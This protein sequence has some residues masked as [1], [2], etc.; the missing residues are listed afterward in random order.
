MR[1]ERERLSGE[2]EI[3]LVELV[4]GVWRRKLWVAL[5]AVPIIGLSI[6]YVLLVPPVYEAKLYVQPPSQNEIAQLNNARGGDSGLATYSV[7]DVYDIYLK[8]LQSEALRNKFFRTEYLAH[9][10]DEQRS[11]SRD[12][13]YSHFNSLI[14]VSQAGKDMPSRYVVT[15]NLEDPRRAADWVTTYVEMASERAKR[16]VLKGSHSDLAIMADNLERQI[17]AAQ[18]GARKQREDQIAQL[19]EALAVAESIGLKRP[20]ILAGD[21]SSEI[22]AGMGGSLTYM[23]GSEALRAEID[24]LK[25]R[26]SDDPFISEL[27]SRQ[28]KLGIY[29]SISIDP[30]AIAVYQ[31]DGAVEQPDKPIKPKKSLIVLLASAAGL[32]LGVMVALARDVWIRRRVMA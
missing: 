29:R 8:A 14:K 16:E 18:A 26:V 2:G 1:N 19:Q 32:G 13:L 28:E 12:A 31:Q 9:L 27:R 6:A 10:T 20:P 21:L 7:K 15:A 30:S 11:G 22:S 23:R 3:D 25:S 5:V 17:Q 4:Q 24:T